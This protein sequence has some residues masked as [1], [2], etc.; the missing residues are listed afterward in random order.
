MYE[1]RNSCDEFGV[2]PLA[3]TLRLEPSEWLS[4]WRQETGRL[5]LPA[6]SEPRLRQMVA[7][8]VRLS[9]RIVD[10]TIVGTVVGIRRDEAR[11]QVEIAPDE[12]GL[13]AVALLT[14]AARGEAVRFQE[15]P[16]RYRYQLPVV[17][18]GGLSGVYMHTISVSEGGCALRWSGSLPP[19]GQKLAL[20]FGVGLR[21][22]DL[23]GVVRW[24]RTTAPSP[25]VGVR[26]DVP[27]TAAGAWARLIAD[28]ARS[29]S[30]AS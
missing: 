18:S 11:R 12:E 5:L 2:S 14:A 25:A 6:S 19:V 24:R 29:T 20:R 26:L 15:R 21:A 7:V 23:R 9:G 3:L 27:G 17:V 10:A 1:G 22:V 30:P 16:P 4:A 13:R 28:A 8:S